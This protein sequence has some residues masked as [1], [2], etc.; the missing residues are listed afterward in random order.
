MDHQRGNAW[1]RHR[2]ARWLWPDAHRWMRSDADRW[3]RPDATRFIAPGGDVADAF[4][5]LSRKYNPGQPRVPAGNPDGG[6]WTDGGGP[7][8]PR[9]R[10]SKP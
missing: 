1:A 8:G 2:R 4:P 3:V 10:T 7:A 6:Q 5:A 9:P